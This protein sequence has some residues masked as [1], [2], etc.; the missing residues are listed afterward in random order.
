MK[1]NPLFFVLIAGLFSCNTGVVQRQASTIKPPSNITSEIGPIQ[2][3]LF[4]EAV[5][6]ATGYVVSY[7]KTRDYGTTVETTETFVFITG[8]EKDTTYYFAVR[9]KNGKAVSSLPKDIVITTT[10]GDANV[11]DPT[12][13]DDEKK[14]KPETATEAKPF[15][16]VTFAAE[17]AAWEAQNISDYEFA[18]Q[19]LLDMPTVPIEIT[20]SNGTALKIASPDSF[21]AETFGTADM[22]LSM[23]YGKTIPEIYA[24]IDAVIKRLQ[25][26]KNES[27][28]DSVMITVSYNEEYH[29]PTYFLYTELYD[30]N[31]LPGGSIGIEISGFEVFD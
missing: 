28:H 25:E 21:P 27:E 30:D 22:E 4:W 26:D 20:V 13:T 24:S 19:M 7:G 14:K 15:D 8:L 3:G 16:S 9:T 23:L 12:F 18:M 1:V 17:K 5:E 2:T 31:P 11:S 10:I 29:Y 6:G